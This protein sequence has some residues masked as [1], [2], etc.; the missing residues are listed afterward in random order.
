MWWCGKREKSGSGPLAPWCGTGLLN[1]LCRQGLKARLLLKLRQGPGSRPLKLQVGHWPVSRPWLVSRQPVL[2]C[3]PALLN[4]LCRQGLKARLLLNLRQGPGSRSLNLQVGHWLMH[5]L[6]GLTCN[7]RTGDMRG[8]SNLPDFL[9]GLCQL[10]VLVLWTEVNVLLMLRL[11]LML[12]L[13]LVQ[14]PGLQWIFRLRL[15][16]EL[17]ILDLSLLLIVRLLLVQLIHSLLLIHRL[18]LVLNNRL[19]LG[20][21]ILIHK[22]PPRPD[23]FGSSSSFAVFLRV[24]K[25][26]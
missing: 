6:P 5:W 20:L 26:T 2:W 17:L 22:P 24:T 8:L 18:L 12:W 3:K 23:V 13:L 9:L 14:V 19:H 25:L 15:L 10:H 11:K 1:L 7:Q 4:L 16:L 21:L